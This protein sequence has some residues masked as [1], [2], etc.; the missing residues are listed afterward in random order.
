MTTTDEKVGQITFSFVGAN[1]TWEWAVPVTDWP[2]IP[3]VGDLVLVELEDCICGQLHEL[4][5]DYRAFWLTR[6]D[7]TLAEFAISLRQNYQSDRR[8]NGDVCN[9]D[10]KV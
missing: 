6:D 4:H 1:H 5:V 8:H 9:L 7:G 2:T 10:Q 3:L